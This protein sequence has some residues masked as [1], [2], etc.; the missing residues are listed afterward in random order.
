MSISPM[1]S[2]VALSMALPV[3]LF[4]VLKYCL[5]YYPFALFMD[6]VMTI[7]IT[8]TNTHTHTRSLGS[9]D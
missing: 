9:A 8:R 5:T 4:I 7:F 1:S 2:A 6:V 3:A